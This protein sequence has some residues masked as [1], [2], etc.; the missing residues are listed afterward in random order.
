[1]ANGDIP[2]IISGNAQTLITVMIATQQDLTASF[3]AANKR[4]MVMV[5]PQR[6]L[7]LTV[8]SS[9]PLKVD[10]ASGKTKMVLEGQWGMTIGS[11]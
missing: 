7:S 10:Q 3:D 6:P 2:I 5:D 8:E 9:A 4:L 11:E 1:M